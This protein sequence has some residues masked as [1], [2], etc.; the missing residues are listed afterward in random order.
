MSKLGAKGHALTEVEYE[1][2]KQSQCNKKCRRGGCKLTGAL[3]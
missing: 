1:S 2:R 3:K